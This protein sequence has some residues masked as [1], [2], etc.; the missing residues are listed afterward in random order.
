MMMMVKLRHITLRMVINNTLII[1][2]VAFILCTYLYSNG[3]KCN[4][5]GS[6]DKFYFIRIFYFVRF[7]IFL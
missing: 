3:H 4:F 2:L 1:S 5:M 7:L 6:N